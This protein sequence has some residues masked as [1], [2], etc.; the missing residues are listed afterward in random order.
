MCSVIAVEDTSPFR[1]RV[2][3]SVFL[4]PINKNGINKYLKFFKDLECGPIEDENGIVR[5]KSLKATV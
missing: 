3:H 5:L 1:M 2:P 4:R